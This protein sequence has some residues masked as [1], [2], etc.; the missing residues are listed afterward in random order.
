MKSWRAFVLVPVLAI[1]PGARA[2][3][4]AEI[5]AVY[6]DWMVPRA[7]E[8]VAESAHLTSRLQAYCAASAQDAAVA[9]D[10]AGQAWTRSLLAWERL[11]TVSIG[12]MPRFRMQVEMDFMPTRPRTIA[13]AVQAAP[14]DAEAMNRIG[15]PAKG[16]PAL[17]WLLWTQRMQP[18]SPECRYSVQ[19]AQQIERDAMF[20]ETG[21]REA[22]ATRLDAA[23]AKA[24]L[25]ELVNQWIGGLEHLRWASME[26]PVRKA[27]TAGPEV[28]PGYP[29]GA[30]GATAA[31][32]AA[33]WE[34]LHAL[35]EGPG[36]G[37]LASM[38]RTRGQVETANDFE[39]A[40]RRADQAMADLAADTSPARVLE[41]ARVLSALKRMVEDKVAPA[42]GVHIGFS[43]SDGD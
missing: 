31:A 29:R 41:S 30:S 13:K 38:L 1:A 42:L 2:D 14:Q 15:A 24:A 20:I 28:R 33:Q 32:W 9:F 10:Q 23:A 22:A 16:F 17:E 19:V 11:S 43:D 18:A 25:S 26:E 6:R 36:P 27:A 5:Q 8:L 34:A 35:A 12:L 4:A 37:S 21:F 39:G 40:L 3:T 7:A